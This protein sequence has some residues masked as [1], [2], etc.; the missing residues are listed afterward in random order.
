M[1]KSQQER[2][3]TLKALLATA[4]LPF[5]GNAM[6][7]DKTSRPRIGLALGSGGARGLSHVLMFEVLEEL[8]LR[9]HRI[10]GCSIGAVMGALYASGMSAGEIQATIE[11]LLG[12][13]GQDWFEELLNRKWSR[14][15]ELLEP[16]DGP[17]G[18]L[19]AA[20]FIRYLR[21][22]TGVS[23]FEELEIPLQV[24][25]TDFWERRMVV[26]DSGELWPAVQGSM[27]LPG[28][29]EPV[30]HQEQ[31]LVD[32]G[33]SNPL[34]YELLLADSDLVIAVDVLGNRSPK[35]GDLMSLPSFFDNSFNTFQIMQYSIMEEKL[36]RRSPDI[37][38]RPKIENVRVLEFHRY[39]E[40]LEQARPSAAK[41]RE[42]LQ[43]MMEMP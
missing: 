23:R 17:G 10:S 3:S 22:L 19:E 38:V 15:L 18:L 27:A 14:W 8:G 21:E 25:V 7:A 35:D 34:P 31:V 42:E 37:L 32:G 36:Q 28:L 1:K 6:A 16:A 12:T 13:H 26:F 33:L 2:R 40:I 5:V 9:P 4:L 41:L 24:V 29:F 43:S 20:P 39:V 30:L 11:K